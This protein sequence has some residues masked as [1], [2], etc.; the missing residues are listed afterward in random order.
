MNPPQT[1]ITLTFSLRYTHS[2]IHSI[3]TFSNIRPCSLSSDYS[4]ALLIPRLLRIDASM[5]SNYEP[6]FPN[7]LFDRSF[8][9]SAEVVQ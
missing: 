4:Y 3:N 7:H 6:T 2:F 9:R 8:D 5:P 1:Y